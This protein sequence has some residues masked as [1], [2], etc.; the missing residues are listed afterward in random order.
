[1]QLGVEKSTFRP[2]FDEGRPPFEDGRPPFEGGRPPFEDGRPP[3]GPDSVPASPWLPN[4]YGYKTKPGRSV[5]NIC[6]AFFGMMF[7]TIVR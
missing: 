1:M 4:D 2:P 7:Q 3:Y 5:K 6:S